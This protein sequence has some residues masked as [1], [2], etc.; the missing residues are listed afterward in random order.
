MP[1]SD[2]MKAAIE[3]VWPLVLLSLIL[4][5]IVAVAA[6]GADAIGYRSLDRTVTEALIRIVMVVGI[7]IFIGNSGV[8]SFGHIGFVCIGAYG[9]AMLTANVRLKS[10][11]LTGLPDFIRYET[12]DLVTAAAFGGILSAVVALLIG[13]ALMRLSGIAASIATFAFLAI[14]QTVY[15]NWDEVTGGAGSIAR[16]PRYVD[17]WVALAWAVVTM[18]AA[19]WFQRS[20]YGLSLKASREN[21][22]AAKA[23]GVD[24]FRERL[25]AFTISGFFCGIA[26]VLYAHYLGTITPNNFYMQMTFVALSMLVVGGINSLS[27]AVLGVVVITFIIETLRQAE[28]GFEIGQVEYALPSGVQEIALG[29]IM[30]LILIFRSGGLTMNREVYWP[31]RTKTGSAGGGMTRAS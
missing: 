17:M 24:I 30:L 27:G 15:L 25:I 29:I 11:N 8:I 2:F 16:I 31:F 5:A 20:K 6:V 19:W 13:I 21:E 28:K 1:Q 7:Y 23:A 18:I 4:L 12:Y 26:G 3:R 14:V 10:L 22:V 9:T